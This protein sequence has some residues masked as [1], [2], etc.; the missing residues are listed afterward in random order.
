MPR[1]NSLVVIASGNSHKL[2]EISLIFGETPGFKLT[3]L[4]DFPAYTP[5]EETGASLEEN[6]LI[7]AKAAMKHTG[8]I[9]IGDDTG[10]FIDALDGAPGILSARFAGKNA[11]DE[12]RRLKVLEV[13]KGIKNREARFICAAAVAIPGRPP[14][15]FTGKAEGYITEDLRGKGGFGYDPI[16]Y[17]PPL[18][19]TFAEIPAEEKNKIGHRGAAFRQAEKY[20][21]GHLNEEV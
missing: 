5:P 14:E 4:K 2:K 16:F 17:F 21:L 12:K 15:I 7:K 13:M 10:L 20:I 9:C 1:K 8:L 3:G 6:A 18:G 19:M 11:T